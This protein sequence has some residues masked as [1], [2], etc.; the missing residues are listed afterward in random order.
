MPKL[1]AV[2][3]LRLLLARLQ[4]KKKKVVFT[5]GCFDI[6]HAGHVRY[7]NKAKKYGDVLVVALNSDSSVK[8]IKGSLRPI[9]P[10]KERAEIMG[11]L[12]AV[13]FVTFFHE[14]TPYKTIAALKPD[15]LVKG[16]DWTKDK[17]IGSDLVLKNG[18]KVKTIHYVQGKS[19]TNIIDSILKKYR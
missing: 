19:T 2:Q 4:G 11:A 7:L 18:G 17:I 10:L 8:K 15:I 6:L 12:K 3:K 16:G 13:D 5:N 1:Y 14:D 9:V